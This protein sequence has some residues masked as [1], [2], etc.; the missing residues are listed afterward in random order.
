MQLSGISLIF[1]LLQLIIAAPLELCELSRTWGDKAYE[2]GENC[3]QVDLKLIASSFT[4]S[5]FSS[6]GYLTANLFAMFADSID[7]VGI[8]A[9]HGP[10]A[11]AGR[12]SK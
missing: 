9:G 7:G 2:R 5:G 1:V 12:C 6:G 11:T 10:C 8:N 3:G 4:V